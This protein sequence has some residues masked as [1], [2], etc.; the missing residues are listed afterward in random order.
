MKA[1]AYYSTDLPY[2]PIAF[3]YGAPFLLS[4]PAVGFTYQ[5]CFDIAQ[6][7]KNDDAF[8]D[9]ER[10][11]SLIRF[12]LNEEEQKGAIWIDSTKL[13]QS[14][15]AFAKEEKHPIS[16]TAVNSALRD[17]QKL[18]QEMIAWNENRYCN[19]QTKELLEECITLIKQ[20]PSKH[21]QAQNEVFKALSGTQ[22]SNLYDENVYKIFKNVGEK[23][24]CVVYSQ[25]AHKLNSLMQTIKEMCKK[26]Q[27]K[28]QS[29][30]SDQQSEDLQEDKTDLIIVPDGE[31][32]N[33]AL[34][35]EILKLKT[36]GIVLFVNTAKNSTIGREL[37]YQN[38]INDS[39]I[40]SITLDGGRRFEVENNVKQVSA[41]S[42]TSQSK[43]PKPQLSRPASKTPTYSN[44]TYSNWDLEKDP[45]KFINYLRSQ[46]VRYEYKTF[47]HAT[48]DEVMDWI[49]NNNVTI[50]SY[51]GRLYEYSTSKTIFSKTEWHFLFKYL[52]IKYYP[53][54]PKYEQ[55]WYYISRYTIGAYHLHDDIK[56]QLEREN[57]KIIGSP[58]Y[59]EYHISGGHGDTKTLT[60]YFYAY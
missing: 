7:T 45:E 44:R 52:K 40:S 60:F 48:E 11:Y 36:G 43:A 34:L 22:I 19:V 21:P 27:A 57:G 14:V 1:S 33:V 50:I 20:L 28:L 23:S 54:K 16:V 4:H 47:N 41:E 37:L 5:E 17:Q 58:I 42:I 55:S 56:N 29:I 13:K 38:L 32:I 26:V 30:G 53:R 46:H 12:Q 9:E 25:E 39:P 2:R 59:T 31:N 49:K 3:I 8:D 15:I 51:T 10:T 18:S 6:A 24:F 35:S